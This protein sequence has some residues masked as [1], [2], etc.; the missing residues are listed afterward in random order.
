MIL[1]SLVEK[2]LYIS[3]A[4]YGFA[5]LGR[6]GVIFLMVLV[7]GTLFYTVWGRREMKNQLES[8]TDGAPTRPKWTLQFAPV[9][10]LTLFFLAVFLGAVIRSWD[11]PFIAKLMPIYVAAIPGIVLALLQLW[12]DV[13]V[14]ER[15]AAIQSGGIEMDE[16]FNESLDRGVE[17]KRTLAFFGWFAGGAAGV[18]LLGIVVALP[19]FIPLY[20]LIE[21]KDKWWISILY[22]V[23]AFLMVWGLF[24]GV[25]K[26]I[27]PEGLLFG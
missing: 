10:F 7:F 26:I 1:G 9:S 3:T 16:T 15:G 24:E 25:F 21:G 19:L 14:R 12:K 22:G 20:M 18:W 13:I 8:G 17:I 11:W 6:P 5:W 27:W 4:A 23:G 2:Y